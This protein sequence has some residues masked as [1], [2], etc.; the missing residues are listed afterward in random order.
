MSGTSFAKIE[1]GIVVNVVEAPAE[2]IEKTDNLSFYIQV[3]PDVNG[4]SEKRFNYPQ[5]GDVYDQENDAFYSPTAPYPSWVMSAS[6][7]WE[8]PIPRPEG[9]FIWDEP[10]LTWVEIITPAPKPD[11]DYIWDEE[12]LSWQEVT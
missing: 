8:A 4:E 12:T 3:F 5:V 6:Y 1:N 7:Q 11:G 2:F 10:T 9:N